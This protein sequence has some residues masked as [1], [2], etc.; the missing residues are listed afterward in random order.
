MI[1]LW[2]PYT[3]TDRTLITNTETS[4]TSLIM[5]DEFDTRLADSQATDVT[6]IAPK[7]F[8]IDEYADYETALNEQCGKFW[9]SDEGLL[10]Y[11]RMRV[12]EVF[13][14]GSADMKSSLA[15]Q[16]GALKRSMDFEADVP[17]FLEPWYGIGTVPAAYGLDYIWAPGQAPAVS[18]K[19][20]ST[21]ELV[22]APHKPIRET[23]IGRHTLNMIEYFLEQTKGRIPM[24]FCDV[25]SPLNILGLAVEVNQFF[26]DFFLDPDAIT[27]AMKQVA[28]LL[29]EFTVDQQKL[30]G[31]AL[32]KPGHG[33][34]SSRMFD[35]F[36]M[37]DDNVVMLS[38]DL[39]NQFAVPAMAKVGAEFGGPVFHSCGNWSEKRR[40]VIAIP[41]VRM[42]DGAFSFATDPGANPTEGFADTFAGTGIV[43]NARIVGDEGLVIQK[44]SSL[45]K[46]GMKLIVVTYCSTPEEQASLYRKLHSL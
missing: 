37:S 2:T 35:G 25:Q 7:D 8:D 41:G 13:A 20:P 21:R 34:S 12:K 23:E 24:S 33:F 9:N 3:N 28:D 17:N 22:N 31:D 36:G 1:Y 29:T 19:F 30:I 15:W 39:Y 46:P 10:V 40:D 32:A 5:K 18:R 14:A 27:E 11:R 43:L 4:S 6:P 42:A 16:L 45:W 44:A 38:S 26:M